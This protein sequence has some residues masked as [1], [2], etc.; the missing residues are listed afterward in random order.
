M[1]IAWAKQGGRPIVAST[2]FDFLDLRDSAT[3]LFW[4]VG[5]GFSSGSSQNSN[6]PEHNLRL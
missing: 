5:Q 2:M 1:E 3:N 6:A 4:E